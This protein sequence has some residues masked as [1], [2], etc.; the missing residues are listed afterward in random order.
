MVS[1]PNLTGDNA[2]RQLQA[3]GFSDEQEPDWRRLVVNLYG[4]EKTGK[5]HF[6]LTAPEPIFFFNIDIG[7][8]GVVD[9]FQVS[10]KKIYVYN[11]RVRKGETIDVYKTLWTELKSR[12]EKVYDVGKGTLVFDTGT[13]AYELCRL[14][15]F[16]KLTEVKPHH[17][18]PVNAEWRELLRTA[19]DSPM[20]TIFIHKAKPKYVDNQ[21]TKEYEVAGFGEMGFMSEVNMTTQ[22]ITKDESGA[23]HFSVLVENCRKHPYVAGTVFESLPVSAERGESIDDPLYNFERLLEAVFD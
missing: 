22:A 10:G 14:A 8:K 16:G 12:V 6:A 21:R 7:T 3:L 11:V 4:R 18:A 1:K 2:I 17:Y 19:Y 13:E 15:A 20:N 23:I 5:T 9:K